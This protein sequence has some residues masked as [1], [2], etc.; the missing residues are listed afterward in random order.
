MTTSPDPRAPLLLGSRKTRPEAIAIQL[1]V[2]EDH[3]P[4]VD[5]LVTPR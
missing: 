5:Q 4:P 1:L 3:I 2:L